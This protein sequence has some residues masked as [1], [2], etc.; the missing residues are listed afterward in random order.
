M[1]RVFSDVGQALDKGLDD[2]RNKNLFD[3]GYNQAGKLEMHDGSKSY[4]L[5]RNGDDWSSDGKKM[6]ASNVEALV[7]KVRT[8]EA[9]KF[10]DSGFAKPVRNVLKAS[11]S[12]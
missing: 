4:L 12:D 10:V 8:L 7:E 5:A 9:D 3:F 1:Y 11:V 6:D 2:F